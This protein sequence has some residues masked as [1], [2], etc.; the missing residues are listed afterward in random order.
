MDKAFWWVAAAV[1]IVI[2]AGGIYYYRTHH[3][4]PPP[5][6]P[7]AQGPLPAGGSCRARRSASDLPA[8]HGTTWRR[9]PL[10]DSDVPVRT[11]LLG[12]FGGQDGR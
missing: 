12:V 11:A 1:V 6:P 8:E 9:P 3:A 5:P 4:A 10:E 7:V 2:V